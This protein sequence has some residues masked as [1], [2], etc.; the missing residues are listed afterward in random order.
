MDTIWDLHEPAAAS[1]RSECPPPAQDS[2]DNEP[3][4][5]D[6]SQTIPA[7]S[8]RFCASSSEGDRSVKRNAA[9]CELAL[10]RKPT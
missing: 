10:W 7:K 8:A 2:N 6:R 5:I 4:F 3:S 1:S 9:E